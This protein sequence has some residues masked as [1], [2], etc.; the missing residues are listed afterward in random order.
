MSF[1]NCDIDITVRQ[2]ARREKS[3]VKIFALAAAASEATHY[4]HLHFQKCVSRK[5][6]SDHFQLTIL[7]NTVGKINETNFLRRSYVDT[8]KENL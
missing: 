5:F 3:A 8:Y 2:Y 7:L 6:M 1:D 4:H